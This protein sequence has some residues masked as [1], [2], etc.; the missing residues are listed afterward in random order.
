M[1]QMTEHKLLMK[2]FYRKISQ[3]ILMTLGTMS[4]LVVMTGLS[5][6]LPRTNPWTFV[7]PSPISKKSPHLY[8]CMDQNSSLRF[9]KSVLDFRSNGVEDCS[10]APEAHANA[11]SEAAK[12]RS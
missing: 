2:R 6:D 10:R 5:A 8:Q 3:N 1:K 12:N 11:D 7:Q 9:L 4:L